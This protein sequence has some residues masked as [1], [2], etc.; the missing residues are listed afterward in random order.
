MPIYWLNDDNCQFPPVEHASG[1]GILAVGGDLSAERLLTAYSSGIFP[2]FNEGDPIT[3]WSPDPRMVLFPSELK[4]SKS[5]K[6]YFNQGKYDISVDK[7][8]AGVMRNCQKPRGTYGGTWI[9]EDMVVAYCRLHELGY[10]HSVE[11]WQ[12]DDMVGGLYGV[13]L[14]KCFFGES[15]FTRLSNASKFGFI[16]MV[17][18]IEALGFWLVDCQ[19][20][21]SHLQSLGARPIKR[22]DF[23]RIMERNRNQTT[24]QGHWG[25]LSNALKPMVMPFIGAET[26]FLSIKKSNSFI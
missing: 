21:T 15:M 4:V 19:Q 18:M 9:T 14:G 11:V 3:W 20:E 24:L 23:T 12:G 10:A 26:P 1:E 6:P 17:K 13:A 8:F 7:D 16:Y 5:M 2:W 25:D 22:A